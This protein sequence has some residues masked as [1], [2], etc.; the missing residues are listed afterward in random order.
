[1]KP[2]LCID[3]RLIHAS[4]LGTFLQ[5]VL[6]ALQE[7]SLHLLCY[8]KD[9]EFLA[10]FAPTSFIEVTSPIYSFQEQVELPLK[11]PVC[12]L[13][14]S[15]HFNIPLLPIRAKKRLTAVHDVFHLVHLKQL[16]LFQKLYAQ[17]VYNA[18]F[19]LSDHVLTV[20]AFSKSQ[21]EAYATCKPKKLTVVPHAV[22]FYLQ[23]GSATKRS[24]FL[25]AVI[26]EGKPHKNL[27]RLLE[28]FEALDIEEELVVVGKS[29]MRKRK[30]VHFKGYVDSGELN[31]LYEQAQA[32]VFPSLYEG[33]GFPVLEAMS[34]GCPVV[35]SS[36]GA[37]REVCGEA[38]E[39]VDPWSI[40][41][42]QEGIKKALKRREELS[43]KGS[44]QASSFSFERFKKDFLAVV[45]ESCRCS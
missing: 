42:I 24:P 30:R 33:F 41:S 5:N 39:Y 1:M 26:G 12:S 2:A 31:S 15:P 19:C 29:E 6:Q 21:I 43:E 9:K 40:T 32:L 17:V 38:A 4:G 10:R 7:F 20:S 28:A 37:L 27:E 14:F 22:P 36:S 18:A 25:L 8:R 3:A 35:T 45:Y 34:K 11:I 23:R 44:F 16:S 13:F